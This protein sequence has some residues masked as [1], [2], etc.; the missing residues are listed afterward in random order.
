MIETASRVVWCEACSERVA[1]IVAEDGRTLC[2]VCHLEERRAGA[3][4]EKKPDPKA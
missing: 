1:E 3:P 4:R 2:S